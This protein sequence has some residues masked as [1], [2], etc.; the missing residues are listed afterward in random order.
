MRKKV[1]KPG[2]FDVFRGDEREVVSYEVHGK[3]TS[4]HGRKSLF[5]D[6]E[7]L[8]RLEVDQT[9]LFHT[10]YMEDV[11][12]NAKY[13]IRKKGVLPCFGRNRLRVF[14]GF[15][16]TMETEKYHIMSRNTVR[17]TF[18]IFYTTTG[19]P[20]ATVKTK[21]TAGQLAGNAHSYDVTIIRDVDEAFILMLAVI[22]DEQC[23]QGLSA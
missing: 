8:F 17:N 20:I 16:G 18:E 3:V 19:V 10:T 9:S 6:G 15:D 22:I 4:L 5:R 21:L 2:F 1:F 12:T 11:R 7:R 14:E 23:F 13:T